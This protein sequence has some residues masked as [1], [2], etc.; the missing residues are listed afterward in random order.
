MGKINPATD[1]AVTRIV[2]VDDHPATRLG[3]GACIAME[4][5]LEV[6]GQAADIA[7]A[8]KVIHETKP[9]IAIIDI[10]LKTDDGIELIKRLK[11]RN[12]SVRIL[13]WSMYEDSLY[14]DRALRAG[15]MGY[16]NKQQATDTVIDAIRHILKGEVYLG[17]EM[18]A[19]VLKRLLQGEDQLPRSPVDCL[20]DRELET[21][22]LIGH[23][24]DTN[25]IAKRM[26]L[27]VKTVETYRAR[28]REKLGLPNGPA[29][30]QRAVQWVLENG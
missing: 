5:D 1:P 22:R 20:A 21:F 24:L 23:G 13:V 28:I 7:E 17:P 29:L 12:D 4:P 6:C 19:Q 15:A 8:M 27:S 14:A 18:S 3:L 30:M 11:Y 10:S 2:I 25:Q 9:D 26:H 16:I